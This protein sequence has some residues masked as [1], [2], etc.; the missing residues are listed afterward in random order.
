MNLPP[1]IVHPPRDTIE[2]KKGLAA[3]ACQ[4]T[5]KPAPRYTWSN[6]DKEI[7]NGKDG[8]YVDE[9]AGDLK[10]VNVKH[11]QTGTFACIFFL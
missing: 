11:D 8:Y 2:A 1:K 9:I 6:Q 5:G 10:I 7:L 3:F 4:A